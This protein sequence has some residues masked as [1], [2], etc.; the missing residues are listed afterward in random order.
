MTSNGFMDPIVL[1]GN[2]SH[3]RDL[4]AKAHDAAQS[5]TPVLLTGEAGVG[6]AFLAQA[7]HAKSAR[8]ARPFV[9]IPCTGMP[10][11]LVESECFGHAR[12]SFEGA[13]RD[14]SGLLAQ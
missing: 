7:I 9:V 10:E 8:R 12:G 6:K 4:E 13:A 1:I 5:S 14:Y 11:R 2:S 3:L